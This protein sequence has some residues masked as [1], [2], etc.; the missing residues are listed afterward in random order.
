[1]VVTGASAAGVA[2][3]R[4][5]LDFGIG[6]LIACDRRG[7]LVAARDRIAGNP[8]EEW[9]AGHTSSEDRSPDSNVASVFDRSVAERIASTVV[10]AVR[11]S[12]RASDDPCG[13]V[14]RVDGAGPV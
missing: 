12:G 2:C 14:G 13:D 4:I 3:S 1:M 8:A 9:L 6:D 10:D 7:A 5:L 11:G